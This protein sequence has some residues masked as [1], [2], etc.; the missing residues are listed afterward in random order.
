MTTLIQA[1]R[2]MRDIIPPHTRQWQHL[3]TAV[4][5]VMEGYGY[6]E[7]RLPIVEA[8][9]LF[10][11]SIGEVTDIVSKEMYTFSDR[12]GDS[13]TLRPEGTA[14]CVRAVI[15]NGLLDSPRRL[16]YQGAMFRRERPQKERYRQFHQVGVEVFGLPGPDIDI[17]MILLTARLWQNLGI[18]NLELQINT[19]GTPKERL[20]YRK[21]LVAYFQEHYAEL[22]TESCQRLEH[23]PLRI[24]DSKIP[25]CN[26]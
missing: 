5:Q 13:L 1:I 25:I 12:N 14:G 3:E 22:D 2:G 16:W 18:N 15:G 9:E 11:R 17:E 7:M 21:V 26:S 19:L 10:Q 6:Q 4:R 23:N 20:D 8:T 24:L